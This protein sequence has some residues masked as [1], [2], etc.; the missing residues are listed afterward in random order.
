MISFFDFKKI[1]LTIGLIVAFGNVAKSFDI[2]SAI[3]AIT[4]ANN[5]SANDNDTANPTQKYN[6]YQHKDGSVYYDSA[7]NDCANFVSQCLIAGGITSI[8][9]YAD[10]NRTYSMKQYPKNIYATIADA[11]HNALLDYLTNY[12]HA[13][14]F[15][16]EADSTIVGGDVL[17]MPQLNPTDGTLIVEDGA[18]KRH[19]VFIVNGGN[20]INKFYYD[21]HTN[22]RNNKSFSNDSTGRIE[23]YLYEY[24]HIYP[25]VPYAK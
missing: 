19:A 14:Y 5:Y 18:I 12:M 1:T 13:A 9:Q 23:S 15:Y 21:A 6:I 17:I 20:G 8:I 4:Y 22:N 2:Y 24:F 3:S 10:A 16:S 11:S 25:T 7:K